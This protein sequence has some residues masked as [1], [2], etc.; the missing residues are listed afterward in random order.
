MSNHVV[1]FMS[2]VLMSQTD[3]VLKYNNAHE[4]FSVSFLGVFFCGHHKNW[5]TL[6]PILVLCHALPVLQ[7]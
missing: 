4:N 2:S 1:C 6:F 3:T 5:S 7:L